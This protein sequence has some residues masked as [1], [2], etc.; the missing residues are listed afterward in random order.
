M[1][2][3]F[4]VGYLP[5]MP[6]V[7]ARKIRAAIAIC[8]LVAAACAV[9]F[10]QVQRTF[11]PSTFEY[12][13]ELTFEGTIEASPYPSLL[14]VRPAT[15]AG[16]LRSSRYTLVGAGKHGADSEIALFASK[17]VQ[18]KGQLIYRNGETLIEVMPG[19]VSAT[20]VSALPKEPAQELGQVTL[21]GEIVDSKCYFGVMN[22]GSGK[23][24]R[25][26]AVRCLSGGIPPS[27]VT[28]DYN[29][30]EATFLLVGRDR[31]RLPKDAFLSLA[32]RIVVVHGQ[33]IRMGDTLY[34]AA[35]PSGI[36]LAP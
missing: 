31:Q 17:A 21:V 15:T 12:G 35:Q 22:P 4:Y 14:V 28:A 26:C 18:L 29:G 33:A 34:L 3:E 36:S 32:G 9:V 11:A 10:A 30:A 19:T 23:V 24:H 6:Q 2:D 5:K 8:L 16:V 1:N 27:F 25:D 20:G 13:K 7:F